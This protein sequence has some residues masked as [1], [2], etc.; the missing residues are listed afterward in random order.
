MITA[1]PCVLTTVSDT[2]TDSVSA[3][4][5][6]EFPAKFGAKQGDIWGGAEGGICRSET[7]SPALFSPFARH[8]APT[9]LTALFMAALNIVTCGHI[10]YEV[11]CGL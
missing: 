3:K 9:S 10:S 2:V 4:L 8:T 11:C 6:D 7:V 1:Y 5:K